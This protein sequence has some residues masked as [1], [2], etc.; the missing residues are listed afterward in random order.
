[1]SSFEYKSCAMR[2]RRDIIPIVDDAQLI[3]CGGTRTV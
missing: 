2:A 1:M 3:S